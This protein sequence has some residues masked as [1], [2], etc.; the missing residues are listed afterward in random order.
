MGE[1]HR[2]GEEEDGLRGESHHALGDLQTQQLGLGMLG[3]GDQP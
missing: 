1:G 2:D 3:E